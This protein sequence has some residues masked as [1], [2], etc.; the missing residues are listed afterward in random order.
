MLDTRG[1]GGRG[2]RGRGRG[3]L[4]RVGG[5]GMRCVLCDTWHLLQK[6]LPSCGSKSIRWWATRKLNG[7]RQASPRAWT[8]SGCCRCCTSDGNV[9]QPSRGFKTI[10]V[11]P[12]PEEFAAGAAAASGVL[13]AGCSAPCCCGPSRCVRVKPVNIIAY[14]AAAAPTRH[15]VT[16]RCSLC[17]SDCVARA[18]GPRCMHGA[19]LQHNYT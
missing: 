18:R 1:A 6:P 2:G 5:E 16:C 13:I 7:W 14:S 8:I 4:C 10:F 19:V 17:A 9:A 15:T 11:G 3:V 12:P